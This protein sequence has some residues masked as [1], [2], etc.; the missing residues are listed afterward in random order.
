MIICLFV[1][2]YGVMKP[3]YSRGS[4]WHPYL[5]AAASAAG[6]AASSYYANRRRPT[7]GPP[8]VLPPLTFT[9]NRRRARAARVPLPG[10]YQGKFTKRSRKVKN[11]TKW[12]CVC[13]DERPAT[14]THDNCAF[15]L[16]C[17]HPPRYVLRMIGMSIVYKYYQQQN[18][19][20]TNWLSIVGGAFTAGQGTSN[21][22]VSLWAWFQRRSGANGGSVGAR[23][24]QQLIAGATNG[25][26]YLSLVDEFCENI[27]NLVNTF[28]NDYFISEMHWKPTYPVGSGAIEYS[29]TPDYRIWDA[30]EMFVS[31]K[32]TSILQVQNRTAAGGG[33]DTS[34][35]S[36]IYANPLE[37]NEYFLDGCGFRYKLSGFDATPAST[38]TYQMVA[39]S[40]TGL[41]AWGYDT[42]IFDSIGVDMWKQPPNGRAI[43][44]CKRTSKIR[45]E[46]GH[47]KRSVASDTVTKSLNGWL[48]VLFPFLSS[49]DSFTGTAAAAGSATGAVIKNY[50]LRIGKSAFVGLEKVAQIAVA[51]KVTLG[52]ERDAIY[53][54]RL[55]FRRRHNT[56]ATNSQLTPVTEAP[57]S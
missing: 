42:T 22:R 34:D 16:H 25:Q 19:K 47:I 54:S 30:T 26:N 37:G 7:G 27:T 15:L 55:F 39:E 48:K 56:A 29:H 23:S 18:I 33:T 28:S 38:N 45:L 51:P 32:G 50:N 36:N 46:P 41:I 17:S 44:G 11:K 1:L 3:R 20:I 31:V 57:G 2:M 9:W 5:R 6:H 49:G 4:A 35:S 21:P 24:Y 14:V 13:K 10:S 53:C 8:V 12:T 43:Y 52:A 40:T